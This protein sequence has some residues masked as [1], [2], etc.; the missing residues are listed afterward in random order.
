MTAPLDPEMVIAGR[1]AQWARAAGEFGRVL[2]MRL[3]AWTTGQAVDDWQH[4]RTYQP[5]GSVTRWDSIPRPR[6]AQ[7][8]VRSARSHQAVRSNRA[9]RRAQLADLRR[10]L[11]VMSGAA[12]VLGAARCGVGLSCDRGGRLAGSEGWTARGLGA[13]RVKPC[14]CQRPAATLVRGVK[15]LR[16]LAP[17]PHLAA[18]I[19]HRGFTGGLRSRF[20]GP[21]WC[22]PPGSIGAFGPRIEGSGVRRHGGRAGR[23]AAGRLAATS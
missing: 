19:H 23:S 20:D 9:P 14:R 17:T 8:E 4:D 7:P 6:R 18:T 11:A 10:Q 3:A 22:Q 12:L 13:D 5:D 16:S 1:T 15:P 2:S 21:W